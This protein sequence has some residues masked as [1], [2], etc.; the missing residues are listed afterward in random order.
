[1][2]YGSYENERALTDVSSSYLPNFFFQL[3]T[4]LVILVAKYSYH[5]YRHVMSYSE[6]YR[7]AY[8][9]QLYCWKK[10]QIFRSTKWDAEN[11]WGSNELQRYCDATK[12]KLKYLTN[13]GN[14]LNN[15]K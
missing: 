15:E 5:T 12:Y 11:A 3:Q 6:D 9:E 14:A 7:D 13:S 10:R 1:M 2:S 4:R 8:L